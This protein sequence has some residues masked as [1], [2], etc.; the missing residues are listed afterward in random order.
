VSACVAITCDC[1]PDCGETVIVDG[2]YT[3]SDARVVTHSRGW[4]CDVWPGGRTVD[5]APG[6]RLE[7]AS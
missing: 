5:L 1:I 7:R 2:A 4:D 3:M 6:H